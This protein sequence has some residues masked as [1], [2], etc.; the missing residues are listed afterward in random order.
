MVKKVR[1]APVVHE[2]NIT[3]LTRTP[4]IVEKY[5]ADLALDL[6]ENRLGGVDQLLHA[7]AFS[8]VRAVF[9]PVLSAWVFEMAPNSSAATIPPSTGVS[10]SSGKRSSTVR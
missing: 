6:G 10:A 4:K 9:R 5:P 3:C 7:L 2:R 8:S 1:M